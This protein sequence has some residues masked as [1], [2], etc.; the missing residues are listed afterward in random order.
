MT[1]VKEDLYESVKDKVS[2]CFP[3]RLFDIVVLNFAIQNNSGANA[4][5]Y[6]GCMYYD[7]FRY[8]AAANL[9]EKSIELIESGINV[10]LDWG[11]WTKTERD[12]AKEFYQKYGIEIKK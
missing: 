8:E 1:T 4:Y 11:F 3:I 5:Y 6:L 12:F 9:F 2:D 10:V 7:K